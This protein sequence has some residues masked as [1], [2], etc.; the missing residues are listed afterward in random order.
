MKRPH[1][2][3]LQLACGLAVAAML[4][5]WLWPSVGWLLALAMVCFVPGRVQGVLW[6][7]FF[8]GRNAMTEGRY[9]I[10]LSHFQAFSDRLHR[11]PR[12]AWG[13]FL[14][15]SAYTWNTRAMVLN[16]VGSCHLLS[17]D[18]ARASIALQSSAALD[19]G[20]ALPLFNLAVIARIHGDETGA[21][22]LR[23][24]AVARGFTGGTRDRLLQMASEVLA[25]AE[26][27]LPA[28]EP[29]PGA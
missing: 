17:G 28:E 27:R 7:E 13:L 12:L 8:R 15:G 5:L 16:N 4:V 24:R 3:L 11:H 10:A 25:R 22:E 2:Y 9:E 14:A 29:S 20:Y 26:G 6:R 21:E 18:I 19:D 23:E 1:F